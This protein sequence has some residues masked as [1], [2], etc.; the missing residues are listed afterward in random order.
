M[1]KTTCNN[2]GVDHHWD[3]EEAFDK[4]GFGDGEGLIMT[5]AVAKVLR[6]AGYTVVHSPWGIHNDCFNSIEKDGISMI[7]EKTNIGFDDPRQYLPREIV[8]LLDEKLGGSVKVF[9]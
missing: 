8:Q 4:Y 9:Q 6:D 1:A 5:E 3:W 7:P 2:C